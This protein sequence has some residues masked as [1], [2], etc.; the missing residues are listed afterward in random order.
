MIHK[1]GLEAVIFVLREN[2]PVKVL[3]YTYCQ[4]L[5]S[6]NPSTTE[7]ACRCEALSHQDH[8]WSLNFQKLSKML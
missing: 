4:L 6:K 3:I 7:Y 1:E 8:L 2:T 5:P